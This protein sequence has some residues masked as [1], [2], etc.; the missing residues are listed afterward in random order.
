MLKFIILGLLLIVVIMLAVALRD[1]FVGDT[2]HLNRSFK[3]RIGLS[4]LLLVLVVGAY[5]AG[6]LGVSEYVQY[7]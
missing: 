1:L 5:L 7:L 4:I 6:L 3:W 2:Q